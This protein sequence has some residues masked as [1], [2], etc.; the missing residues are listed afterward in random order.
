M[1][2]TRSHEPLGPGEIGVLEG[3]GEA[4]DPGKEDGDGEGEEDA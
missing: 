2:V 3:V 4:L 1:P